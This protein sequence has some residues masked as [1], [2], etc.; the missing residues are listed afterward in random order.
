VRRTWVV[1]VP[2]QRSIV[3]VLVVSAILAGIG[4][5]GTDR[6]TEPGCREDDPQIVF[7][8]TA[9]NAA[10]E[11]RYAGWLIDDTGSVSVISAWREAAD[12]L[13]AIEGDGLIT[14][15]E[16][17]TL[18]RFAESAGRIVDR[19]SLRAMRELIPAAADGPFTE[20]ES[21]C[22][23]CGVWHYLG[24]LRDCEKMGYQTVLLYQG[25]D[26]RKTNDS[27]EAEQLHEWLDRTIRDFPIR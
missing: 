7:A 3:L 15:S 20:H 6:C 14:L 23:D 1:A 26:E 2:S 27:P 8:G 25:G 9:Y 24:L 10:W 4:G 11:H 21:E 5:C 17:T 13:W 12:S 16:L 22:A 18:K 19:D